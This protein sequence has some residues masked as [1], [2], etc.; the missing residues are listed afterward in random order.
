M[1]SPPRDL[2]VR[3][4]ERARRGRWCERMRDVERG[5]HCVERMDRRKLPPRRERLDRLAVVLAR[6]ACVSGR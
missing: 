1:S 6:T 4:N 3:E 2:L 5:A